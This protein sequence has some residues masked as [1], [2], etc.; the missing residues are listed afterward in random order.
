MTAGDST[1]WRHPAIKFL[2]FLLGGAAFGYAA[3]SLLGERLDGVFAEIAFDG[4]GLAAYLIALCYL[5]MG[6]IVG[7]GA[8]FPRLGALILNTYGEEELR[9]DRAKLLLGSATM[10]LFGLAL[11]VMVLA[12]AGSVQPVTAAVLFFGLLLASIVPYWPMLRRL[13]ELDRQL[14]HEAI[15]YTYY[16]L[17][18]FGGSWAALGHL[19]LMRGPATLDWLSMFWGLM[20]VATFVAAGRRGL[21]DKS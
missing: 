19:E 14:S 16:A 20:M 4:S 2:G 12:S 11:L 18:V 7:A 15:S 9:E 6:A 17:L 10:I 8:A 13:D 5:V 1:G 21:L 3:G